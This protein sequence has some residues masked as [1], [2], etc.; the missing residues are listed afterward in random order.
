MRTI[1][2]EL[3]YA[4]PPLHANQRLHWAAKA[5]I[6]SQLR[7]DTRTLLSTH[8]VPRKSA[9]VEI[10]LHYAPATAGRRDAGGRYGEN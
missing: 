5:R 1:T 6:T 10:S 9:H 7:R 8:K 3:P 4:K 2:I